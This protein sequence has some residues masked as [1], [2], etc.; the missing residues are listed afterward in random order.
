MNMNRTKESEPFKT[1][2]FQSSSTS[3]PEVGRK[4]NFPIH[5]FQSRRLVPAGNS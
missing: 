3:G 5:S 1:K 4:L 2:Q